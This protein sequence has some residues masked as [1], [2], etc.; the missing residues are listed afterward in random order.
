VGQKPFDTVASVAAISI[1]VLL[2]SQ[3]LGNVPVIQLAKPNISSLGDEQKRIAWLVVSF[4]MY[5]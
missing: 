3:F 5:N 2:S 1:F 4:G